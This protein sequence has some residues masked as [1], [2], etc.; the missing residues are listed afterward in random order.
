MTVNYLTRY[1]AADFIRD[2]FGIPCSG[3]VTTTK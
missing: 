2:H 1:E 3:A